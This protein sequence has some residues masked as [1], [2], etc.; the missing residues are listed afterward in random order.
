MVAFVASPFIALVPVMAHHLTG[1][2]ARAVAQTTGLLT[3]A[4]GVGAVAGALALAPLAARFGRGRVLAG[5]LVL[6]PVTLV[7]YSTSRTPWWGAATLFAV[8]LVYIGVLSGLS[9]VVQLRAPQAYRGRV[10]SFYLVALGVAYPVGSLVQGPVIDRIGI[11]WTTAASAV[12]LA[13]VMAAVAAWRPGVVRAITTLPDVPLPDLGLPGGEPPGGEPPGG[14]RPD[15]PPAPP[16]LGRE[17]RVVAGVA[18][19]HDAGVAA[20]ADRDIARDGDPVQ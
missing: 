4:Q 10:L 7:A 17:L 9:T 16:G 1:G 5:S 15:G 6:L 20:D 11:G 8:G 2:G 13:L 12:L 19:A 14:D 3:T 18:L